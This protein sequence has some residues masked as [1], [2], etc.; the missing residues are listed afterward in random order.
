MSSATAFVSRQLSDFDPDQCKELL[1]MILATS[2]GGIA[3]IRSLR[4]ED[5][6][7]VDFE[8]TLA[9]KVIE[10]QTG[11]PG[12]TAHKLSALLPH[13]SPEV[14]L[15]VWIEVVNG[16][17][18]V[19]KEIEVLGKKD[20]YWLKLVLKK[21]QDSILIITEDITNRTRNEE[22]IRHQTVIFTKIIESS[23]DV[24]QIVS[25]T[26]GKSA[27]INKMLL[28]ELNYPFEDIKRIE[29]A[30]VWPSLCILMTNRRTMHS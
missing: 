29:A 2:S 6:L 8:F 18:P 4:G 12:L 20:H 27:Y 10:E 21:F 23:P 28:E 26:S 7:I 15:A 5:D 9:N 30:R 16:G 25:L 13:I 1:D 14:P 11:I 24:I 19:D 22:Q 3:L 17:E